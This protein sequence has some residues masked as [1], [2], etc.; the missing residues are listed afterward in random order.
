[1]FFLIVLEIDF[2]KCFFIS[3]LY[4]YIKINMN[5]D[6]YFSCIIE[7]KNYIFNFFWS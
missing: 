3:I 6:K 7:E 2:Y 1:M 5:I 4:L